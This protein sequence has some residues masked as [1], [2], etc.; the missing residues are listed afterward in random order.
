MI[1]KLN[2]IINKNQANAGGGHHLRLIPIEEIDWRYNINVI[3]GE[4]IGFNA[5]YDA[6]FD[7][8]IMLHPSPFSLH[9]KEEEQ[10]ETSEP[11]WNVNITCTLY[12]SAEQISLLNSLRYREFIVLYHANTFADNDYKVIGDSSK[13]MRFSVNLD[14]QDTPSKPP[15]YTITGSLAMASLPA[16]VNLSM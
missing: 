5:A 16:I 4:I 1:Y 14:G 8:V 12:F 7:N 2:N 13:G 3:T 15:Q 10:R 9:Y 6:A 11:F